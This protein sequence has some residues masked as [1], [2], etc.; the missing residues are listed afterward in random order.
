MENVK[1]NDQELDEVSGGTQL[2]YI[3][4]PGDTLAALAKKYNCTIEQLCRWNNIKDPNL[5]MVGQRL[6][7]KF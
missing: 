2:P 4:K 6:V 3:V 5:L 7:I 1:L